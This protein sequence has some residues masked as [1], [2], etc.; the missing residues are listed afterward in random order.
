MFFASSNLSKEQLVLLKKW[1][2]EHER[3]CR[4]L[5]ADFMVFVAR[6]DKIETVIRKAITTTSEQPYT[7]FYNY[8]LMD[9]YIDCFKPG[10][11]FNE[12]KGRFE[13]QKKT[14]WMTIKSLED[15]KVRDE[16]DEIKANVLK[17]DRHHFFK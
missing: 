5:F 11:I 10:M 2:Q 4:N 17:K 1:L 13:Y 15:N 8:Y 9:W 14:D 6:F 12:E 3:I 7:R 16:I